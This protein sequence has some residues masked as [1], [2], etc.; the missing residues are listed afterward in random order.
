[1]ANFDRN[2]ERTTTKT[3]ATTTKKRKK[4][5]NHSKYIERAMIQ[6]ISMLMA[7]CHRHN[8]TNMPNSM[9][10]KKFQEIFVVK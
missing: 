1:M 2:K 4:E 6:I 3:A 7:R 9:Q 8:P 5:Y 10:L